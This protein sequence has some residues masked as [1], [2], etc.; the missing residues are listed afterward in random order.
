MGHWLA[1]LSIRE[2]GPRSVKFPFYSSLIP[3]F[4]P[5]PKRRDEGFFESPAPFG[6]FLFIFIIIEV[7]LRS[8]SEGKK[9]NGYISP[10]I[11]CNLSHVPSFP[12]SPA[13]SPSLFPIPPSTFLPRKRKR[14][15]QARQRKPKKKREIPFQP[16]PPSINKLRSSI[17]PC[18]RTEKES[19][20]LTT[21]S[22]PRR[23]TQLSVPQTHLPRLLLIIILD[24]LA[25]SSLSLALGRRRN[26]GG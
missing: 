26:D 10:S 1:S 3:N 21:S 19:L 15:K 14:K 24:V 20:K 8:H 4:H 23:S 16:P 2:L 12:L 11:F 22:P 13:S 7:E 18:L 6:F 5:M 9:R 17:A 25:P